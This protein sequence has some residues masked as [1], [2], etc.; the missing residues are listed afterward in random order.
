[1]KDQ[2]FYRTEWIITRY[3]TEEDFHLGHASDIVDESGHI[4][5]AVSVVE[6][7]LM[8]AEGIAEAWDLILGAGGTAFNNANSYIG[9]GDSTTAEAAGQTDLQASTNKL[10]KG[11]DATYPQRATGT[12]TWR[13][14]FGG[15]EA[16]FPWQEFTVSNS[17]SGTGKNLNR[18]VSNQG[19][20][21]SGQTWTIDL[22]VTLS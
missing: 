14:T 8:L 19:T 12:A 16:N 11:M 15:S 13:A 4:L 9:V 3:A 6:G 5:P 18:K 10:Y 2:V 17:S 21:A 1:M 20:K 22:A 7:N